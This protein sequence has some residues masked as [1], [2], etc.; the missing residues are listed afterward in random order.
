MCGQ[1]IVCEICAAM[2]TGWNLCVTCAGISPPFVSGIRH[3]NR[4]SQV[5]E[6]PASFYLCSYQGGVLSLALV[7]RMDCVQGMPFANCVQL[8]ISRCY[9]VVDRGPELPLPM[10]DDSWQI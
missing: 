3:L 6:V 7:F 1:T 10:L 9:F 2:K 8:L 5:M 4:S